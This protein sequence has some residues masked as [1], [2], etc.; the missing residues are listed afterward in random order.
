MLEWA[1]V[2]ATEIVLLG[3]D[4]QSRVAKPVMAMIATMYRSIFFHA[5]EAGMA[6]S[7]PLSSIARVSCVSCGREVSGSDS[8]GRRV[9]DSVG[10]WASIIGQLDEGMIRAWSPRG[11]SALRRLGS[12]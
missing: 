8:R 9:K 10:G 7:R 2:G 3:E 4:G 6:R 1:R 12:L 5:H 11:A